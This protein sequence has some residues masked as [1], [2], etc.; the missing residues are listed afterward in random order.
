MVEPIQ[1]YT[2]VEA[3]TINELVK[4]TNIKTKLGW[5]CL[6]GMCHTPNNYCEADS[7]CYPYCQSMYRMEKPKGVQP[8]KDFVA[9]PYEDKKPQQVTPQDLPP[10][11]SKVVIKKKAFKNNKKNNYAPRHTNKNK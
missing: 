10:V 3:K 4:L 11:P 1:I 6:G 9:F 7:S 2:V 8:T 5:I